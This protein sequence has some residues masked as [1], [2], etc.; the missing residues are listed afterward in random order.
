M[1]VAAGA[2]NEQVATDLILSRETIKT[3]VRNILRKL[4]LRSRAQLTAHAYSVGLMTG[5]AQQMRNSPD[6][7]V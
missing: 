1:L 7:T 3:H 2:T 6:R 5:S 4:D